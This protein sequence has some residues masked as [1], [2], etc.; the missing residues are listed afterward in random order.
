MYGTA[1]A[2]IYENHRCQPIGSK[3]R[4]DTPHPLPPHSFARFGF[5]PA[6]IPE[7]FFYFIFSLFFLSFLLFIFYFIFCYTLVVFFLQPTISLK[8]QQQLAASIV[9]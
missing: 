8:P 3:L 9:T 6:A 1:K 7:F 2:K 4:A 5:G